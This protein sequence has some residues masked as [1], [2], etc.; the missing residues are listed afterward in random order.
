MTGGGEDWMGNPW[1]FISDFILLCMA[2]FGVFG[3]TAGTPA[4]GG[5]WG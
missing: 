3:D 5:S 4:G 1:D 2:K